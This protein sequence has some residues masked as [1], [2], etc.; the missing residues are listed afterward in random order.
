VRSH[1]VQVPQA[2]AVPTSKDGLDDDLDNGGRD[3]SVLQRTAGA[4]AE[5]GPVRKP[6]QVDATKVALQFGPGSKTACK[7]RASQ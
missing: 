7:Y 3:E 5:I 1:G 2:S 4:A 6:S